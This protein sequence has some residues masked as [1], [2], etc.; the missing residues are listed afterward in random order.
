M[1]ADVI[2]NRPSILALL[3]AAL[4]SGCGPVEATDADD[5]AAGKGEAVQGDDCKAC[6]CGYGPCLSNSDCYP[7]NKCDIPSG[8][9]LDNNNAR[10]ANIFETKCN[11]WLNKQTSCS[12]GEVKAKSQAYSSLT[13][14]RVA[15]QE[16]GH[17]THYYAEAFMKRAKSVCPSCERLDARNDGC[18]LFQQQDAA[19]ALAEKHFSRHRSVRLRAEQT[20]KNGEVDVH[21]AIALDNGKVVVDYVDCAALT[22]SKSYCF[23]GSAAVRCSIQGEIRTARCCTSAHFPQWQL[24]ATCKLYDCREVISTGECHRVGTHGQCLAPDGTPRSLVCSRPPDD[25]LLWID[26]ELLWWFSGKWQLAAGQR[27]LEMAKNGPVAEQSTRWLRCD[28][29][30]PARQLCD[31]ADCACGWQ[32]PRE[33][34]SD[35]Y[36]PCKPRDAF[37]ASGRCDATTMRCRER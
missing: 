15:L 23:D 21:M 22:A 8:H 2:T 1:R 26:G 6:V 30:G 12:F 16:Y 33:E 5:T 19:V 10:V 11:T 28:D 18:S 20:I 25:E 36:W 7:R 14:A 34:G 4:L 13:C 9:C 17:G 29:E 3:L 37:C 27:P 31:G 32:F 35:T 24:G